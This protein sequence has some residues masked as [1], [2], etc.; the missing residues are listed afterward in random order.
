MLGAALVH[1]E[2]KEV[3]PLIPEIISR[4]DGTVKNDCELNASRR[5]LSKL[6]KEHPHLQLVVTQDAISP[7]GPYIRFLKELDYRFILNVK[8]ADHAHLFAR[9]E[10]AIE[11]CQVGELIIDDAKDPERVHYFRWVNELPINASHQD[12]LV[13]L[14]E[15]LEV[16]GKVTK[17]FCWVTDIALSEANAYRIMR[18]GRARWKIESAPQAHGKEV[19]YELTDCA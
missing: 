17:R 12:V 9:F 19:Q 10:D 14:L 13:N 3:I 7:N 11:Q 16:N 8:E 2:R 6:R 5:F 15:Y 4:Q 18:A 1:P